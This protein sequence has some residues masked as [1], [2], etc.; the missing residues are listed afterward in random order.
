MFPMRSATGELYGIKLREIPPGSFLSMLGLRDD[1][2]VHDVN[3]RGI[4]GSVREHLEAIRAARFADISVTRYGKR[5]RILVLIDEDLPDLHRGDPRRSYR[6]NRGLDPR[7]AV[8][9]LRDAS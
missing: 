7:E 2:T 3:G 5:G 6:W 9:W 4:E 8:R 1:D